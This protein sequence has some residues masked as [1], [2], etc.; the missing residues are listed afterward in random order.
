MNFFGLSFRNF[1]KKMKADWI[2]ESTS[3]IA[4]EQTALDM[5]REAFRF[6]KSGSYDDALVYIGITKKIFREAGIMD[7]D[8]IPLDGL[9]PPPELIAATLGE[10][11]EHI[12]YL[13]E[14][15]NDK[16]F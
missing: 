6:F 7:P 3:V 16:I 9:I 12:I 14:E 15:K 2:A 11:E 1:F 8:A 4:M 10:F 13:K 5:A